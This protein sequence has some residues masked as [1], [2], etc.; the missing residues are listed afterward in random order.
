MTR[1]APEYRILPFSDGLADDFRQ[2]NEE[3]LERYFSIEPIDARVLGNPRGHVI[4]PGGQ[5]LFAMLGER[6]VGT[7]AI[8]P[9]G[10]GRYELTKM[11]VTAAAQGRGCGRLLLLA[12]IDWFVAQR[13]KLLFLESHSSLVAALALYQRHG[14]VLLPRPFDSDYAR[15]DVYMEWR[16]RE[17]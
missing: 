4:E 11:A 3:W 15:S 1:A 16:G 13:G 8:K 2:L 9:A 6:A 12:A 10:S 17:G 5:I 7:C 14:F